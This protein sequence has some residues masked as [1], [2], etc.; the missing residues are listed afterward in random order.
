MSVHV[1]IWAYW[2]FGRWAWEAYT[3]D[4]SHERATLVLIN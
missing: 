1:V 2:A 3:L 4:T